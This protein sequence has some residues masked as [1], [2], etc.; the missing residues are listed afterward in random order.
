MR[1]RESQPP[2][3]DEE[4]LTDVEL[5]RRQVKYLRTLVHTDELTG[6]SNLRHFNETL[7]LEL[8]R[9]RRTSQPTCLILM[10]LDNFKEVNDNYGHEVGNSVL[11]HLSDLMRRAIRRLDTPCRFGGD[12]FAIILPGTGL[13]Q[14]IALAER[15]RTLIRNSPFEMGSIRLE[16]GASMGVGV[17]EAERGDLSESEF[18]EGV[19][20][21]LYQSKRNDRGRICID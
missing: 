9:T 3:P 5:L 19:D 11:G 4:A 10:D 8:E 21:L 12:E 1:D 7:G 18:I 20:R 14:G 6:L 17:Y 15:L 13:D 16:I 2:P